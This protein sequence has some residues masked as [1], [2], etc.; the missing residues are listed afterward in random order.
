M[1]SE[2]GV[3]CGELL[4]SQE[5]VHNEADA[6]QLFLQL[7]EQEQVIYLT[8]LRALAGKQFHEPDPLEKVY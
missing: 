5:S 7:N 1:K 3:C 2:Q 4:R 8:R 6:L